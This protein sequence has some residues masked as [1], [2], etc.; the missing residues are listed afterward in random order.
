MIYF[1]A[2]QTNYN[3]YNYIFLNVLY[4]VAYSTGIALFFENL[5]YSV[6][7]RT[8]K[9]SLVTLFFEIVYYFV[10]IEQM[11]F[12]FFKMCS[13]IVAY[14]ADMTLFFN[15]VFYFVAYK[16]QV[17]TL[18]FLWLMYDSIFSNVFYCVCI[19]QLRPY[20]PKMC[21]ILLHKESIILLMTLFF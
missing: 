12:Y 2:Y 5:S 18:Y 20:F 10:I 17:I 16:T 11:K 7:I 9:V 14:R 19:K 15:T 6:A 13:Y 8:L 3:T 4:F 21:S 1:V